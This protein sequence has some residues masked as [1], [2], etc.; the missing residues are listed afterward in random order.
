LGAGKWKAA[1]TKSLSGC[2]E[3]IIIA[4]KDAPGRKHASQVASSTVETETSSVEKSYGESGCKVLVL[5][6]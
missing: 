4:D 5:F 3:A 6:Q 1:Y 2:K